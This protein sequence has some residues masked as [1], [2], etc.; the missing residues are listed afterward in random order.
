MVQTA[1]SVADLR[2]VLD[3]CR[4][5]FTVEQVPSDRTD[6]WEVRDGALQHVS[7]GFFS[8]NGVQTAE[9]A[10]LMLY[11]PQAAVTGVL[12]ARISGARCVLLQ[13][14]AEPGCL[15]GAQ[16]GPTVQSTPANFMRLHG[17]AS[18]PYVEGF[19]S[20]LPTVSIL[21]D[22]TQL[23][24]GERYLFKTKRS[25][26]LEEARPEAPTGT[27]IWAAPDV[28]Q[29]AV[30]ETAFLN[31]DLR[32]VLAIMPWSLD[33]DAGEPCPVA[34]SVHASLSATLRPEI[35]GE[36]HARL[37]A[38]PPPHRPFV[39][40]STLAN[41]QQTQWGWSEIEPAQGFAVK[42]YEVEAAFREVRRWVQPLV[43]SADQGEAILACRER[44]G[45]LEVC[46]RVA[47][48]TGLA[49]GIACLP[50]HLR[51]PGASGATPDWL[52]PPAAR[53]WHETVE[54]DEG[55]RFFQDASRYALV[56]VDDAT[57]PAIDGAI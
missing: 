7:G 26:V 43:D 57:V 23:D 8:V 47:P 37:N 6:Q 2:A 16:F 1:S 32:S 31:I 55:G 38:A 56:R 53:I 36:V 5:N 11:Q 50:T 30:S 41:W 44:Q 20:Y 49:G 52:Q 40:L 9:G 19:I 28:L 51:Y 4:A 21:Q 14:R 46:V 39:P 27:F 17:G 12:T 33:P 3:T 42:F 10:A 22:T 15:G 25:I 13:G 54:S 29:S 18:T 35:L 24:L 34:R 48:E 45:R